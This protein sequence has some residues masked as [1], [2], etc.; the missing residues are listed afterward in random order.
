MRPPKNAW[1][2]TNGSRGV[3]MFAQLMNDMLSPSTFESFRVYSLDTIARLIEAL[4][5]VE[6]VKRGRI[7]HVTLKPLYDELA[8]SFDKDAA[9]RT[10]AASE[11]QSLMGVLKEGNTSKYSDLSSHIKLVLRLISPNYKTQLEELI[12]ECFSDTGKRS[13]LRKT[14]GFYC[15][16]II[17][18]GYQRKYVMNLVQDYF[19]NR[20]ISRVGA[21]TLNKFFRE[22]DGKKKKFIV[23]AAVTKDLGSYLRG[24]S[25]TVRDFRTLNNEQTDVLRENT[26]A[27]NLSMILET[28]SDHFDSYGAMAHTY[29]MLSAQRAIAYLDPYGM[30][31]EWGDTMHV[32]RARAKT[33]S[34]VTKTDFLVDS[35]LK[36]ASSS[37]NRLRS[38]RRYARSIM[39]QF[40]ITST[41]RLLSSINTA[42]LARTS[43]N[44]ENQLISFWSAIEVL[45]SE[46]QG[47]VRIVHYASL[48][49]PCIVLRH[50][51]RQLVTMYDELLVSYRSRF[52]R[53]VTKTPTQST[54]HTGAFAELMFLPEFA[55]QRDE[56][57]E[58]VKSNPLA[59]HRLWKLHKDYSDIKV[60]N[61]T[62]SDHRRRVEWQIHRI[63]RARN[64]LVHSG[65][66]PN[67][68]E[69]LILNLAG[70]YT[71]SIATIINRA[72]RD[73]GSSEIDQ[74]V[75]EIG[76]QYSI[77]TDHLTARS[78]HNGP[79]S[80]EDLALLTV[81]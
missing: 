65:Q 40:D 55:D 68:L 34:A 77:L 62:I 38:I 22:F 44:P 6:D 72:R 78:A 61:K 81:E 21:S 47:E 49:V 11:C 23:H 52:R 36:N 14:T 20:D 8:W 66:M 25:Y 4:H 16:H 3:L 58:L 63:Y 27:S 12:V 24:L 7:P 41:E 80:R 37:G 17:N 74:V 31:C 67:Y 26:N 79:L 1:P 69:S 18:I 46:P 42:A 51:R 5:L 39:G 48:I 33:G 64:Q 13:L 32:A 75:S 2:D 53:L 45:L 9:A 35:A 50:T 30:R 57:C 59:L 56:L 29:Q 43:V 54:G 15:S 10:L 70:Y 76:I 60:A 73:D 28:S 19:F 71:S